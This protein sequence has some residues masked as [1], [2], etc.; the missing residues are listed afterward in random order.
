[1]FWLLFLDSDLFILLEAWFVVV[2]D[3]LIGL[4]LLSV[5]LLLISAINVTKISELA[6]LSA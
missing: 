5:H 2:K 6:V 3:L 1:L 4:V